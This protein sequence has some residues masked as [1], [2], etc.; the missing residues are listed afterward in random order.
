L[1]PS[2]PKRVA[3]STGLCRPVGCR[4]VGMS[5][6]RLSPRWFVA[7]LTGDPL[8]SAPAVGDPVGI[9]WRCL[10]LVKLEWWA[11]VWWKNYDDT[12]SR[13]HTI[14]ACY[15][16][17]DGRTDGQTELLYQYCASV[18]WRAIKKLM[19]PA[20]S[21]KAVRWVGWVYRGNCF[22]SVVIRDLGQ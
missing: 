22:S 11:T 7:Q 16:Q 13:F 1:S 4:P 14:P 2:W 17:T 8:F 21:V 5:P 15:E 18:C 20:E 9:S 6:S 10:M 12:L 3:Q 19:S